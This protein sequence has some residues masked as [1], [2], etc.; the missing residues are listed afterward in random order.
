MINTKPAIALQILTKLASQSSGGAPLLALLEQA[1]R[2]IGAQ[3]NAAPSGVAFAF[4]CL[5]HTVVVYMSGC[6]VL[7]DS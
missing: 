2:G 6:A 1:R 3:Q 5:P 4:V 7:F